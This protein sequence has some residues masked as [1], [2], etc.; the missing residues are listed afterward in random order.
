[1]LFIVDI[2]KTATEIEEVEMVDSRHVARANAEDGALGLLVAR[3]NSNIS[4][5]ARDFEQGSM[6]GKT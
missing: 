4:I 1:V 5:A 3:F 6:C 2:A